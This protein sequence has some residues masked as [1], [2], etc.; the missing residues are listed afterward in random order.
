MSVLIRGEKVISK[1]KKM[2]RRWMGSFAS[3]MS[4]VYLYVH[5][6]G[7]CL[8][9]QLPFTVGTIV[10]PTQSSPTDNAVA[11]TSSPSCSGDDDTRHWEI[12]IPHR[13]TA[14]VHRMNMLSSWRTRMVSGRNPPNAENASDLHVAEETRRKEMVTR[15]R[16]PTIE[17]SY[18]KVKHLAASFGANRDTG[19]ENLRDGERPYGS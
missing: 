17:V 13:E 18:F 3:C 19:S 6:R 1:T 10:R 4:D 2:A 11:L 9:N 12:M 5:P 8:Y 14:L 15:R 7:L 16:G